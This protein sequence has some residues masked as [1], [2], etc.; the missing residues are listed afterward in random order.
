MRKRKNHVIDYGSNVQRKS[1]A[2]TYLREE[3]NYAI[4]CDSR[5]QRMPKAPR[6]FY[7]RKL[8]QLTVVLEYKECQTAY[9]IREN[10]YSE[11][12]L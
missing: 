7:K 4:D 5:V 2:S 10:L 8:A 6:M 12:W 3:K 11:L 1:K 9:D